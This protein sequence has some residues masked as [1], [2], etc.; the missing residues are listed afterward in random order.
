MLSLA[1]NHDFAV[2]ASGLGGFGLIPV[3][4]VRV[5][6]LRVITCSLCSCSDLDVVAHW[7][8]EV[9]N[10]SADELGVAI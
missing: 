5:D 6:A 9:T 2:I 7:L 8:V 3:T 1:H 10:T 4:E